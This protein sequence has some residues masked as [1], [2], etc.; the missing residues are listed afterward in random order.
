LVF[1]PEIHEY[2]EQRWPQ[3]KV[4]DWRAWA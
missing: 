1:S 2:N 3:L 4:V